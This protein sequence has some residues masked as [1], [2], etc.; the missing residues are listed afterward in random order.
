MKREII[1][2]ND[3]SSSLFVPELNETYHSIHGAIAEAKHVFLKKGLD[4]VKNLKPVRIIEVGFG[5]GLN[6][7]LT[8]NKAIEEN[9][10]IEYTGLEKYPITKDEIAAVNYA[11]TL[12]SEENFQLIHNCQWEAPQYITENFT[13]TK[14]K[15]DLEEDDL[16]GDFDLVYFDAFAPNK[17]ASMWTEKVFLKL[18]NQMTDNAL[19]VTYCCQG[20]VKRTL[21]KAG[22]HVEKTDG[23][24]GKRE[25]LVAR[26]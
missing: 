2:T 8:L 7:L 9:L 26:K 10:K 19:L 25:M 5:T 3:G 24:P 15:F 13:L 22:F 6:A 18:Y 16:L 4:V 21:K 20:Q 14:L 23:P 1:L 17:Q 11:S 12:N